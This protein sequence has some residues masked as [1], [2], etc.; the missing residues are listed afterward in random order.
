MEKIL[1]IKKNIFKVL[2]HMKGVGVIIRSVVSSVG[3][4]LQIGGLWL[5]LFLVF[6]IAGR[7]L[8]HETPPGLSDPHFHFRTFGRAMLTLSR[9]TRVRTPP[10]PILQM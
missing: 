1:G 10:L 6:A 5:L 9:G 2:R 8:F 7:Y 3:K 4:V